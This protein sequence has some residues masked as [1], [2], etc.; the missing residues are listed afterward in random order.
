M[1]TLVKYRFL[2]PSLSLFWEVKMSLCVYIFNN[3]S[4]GFVVSFAV[5]RT[6]VSL[7][8]QC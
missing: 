8:A 4:G 1:E 2:G 3:S 5:L 6:A 7:G